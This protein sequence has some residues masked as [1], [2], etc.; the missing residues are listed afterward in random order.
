MDPYRKA[1]CRCGAVTGWKLE[2]SGGQMW[3]IYAH[4]SNCH[5]CGRYLYARTVNHDNREMYEVKNER[6]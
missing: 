3:I 2:Y 4:G 5:K 6:E 1:T